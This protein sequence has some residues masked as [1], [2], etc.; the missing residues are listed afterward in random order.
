L[1][2]PRTGHVLGVDAQDLPLP[3][4]VEVEVDETRQQELASAILHRLTGPGGECGANIEDLPVADAN[5][6]ALKA[7]RRGVEDLRARQEQHVA[8]LCVGQYASH[9]AKK[10]SI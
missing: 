2:S 1:W 5:I 6:P 8:A 4:T 7:R 9:I 3:E 10:L